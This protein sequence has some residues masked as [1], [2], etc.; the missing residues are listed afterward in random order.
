MQGVIDAGREPYRQTYIYIKAGGQTDR[1][2]GSYTCWQA[3]IHIEKRQ[4]GRVTDR[5]ASR[6]TYMQA[7]GRRDIQASR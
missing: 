6:Q 5:Q 1:H 3:N 7:G 4:A 2:A